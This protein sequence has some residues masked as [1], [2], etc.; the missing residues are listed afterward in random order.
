[1][2]SLA[3]EDLVPLGKCLDELLDFVHGLQVEEIPYFY[4]YIENM[5]NNLEICFLV[6]YEGWEQI[7]LLLRRD[8]SAAN[9][10]LVG[11]PDFCISAE[12]PSQKAKLEYEFIRLTANV[13]KY[14]S[15]AI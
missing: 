5:K 1:M 13:E 8:W 2:K 9:H 3:R 12:E 14:F 15:R 4:K 6:H 7:E 10:V 11:M